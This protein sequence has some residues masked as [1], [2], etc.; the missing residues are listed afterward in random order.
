MI[1]YV[2]YQNINDPI[3]IG[4]LKKI[5]AQISAMKDLS[6][7]EIMLTYYSADFVYLCDYNGKVIKREFAFTRK[8]VGEIIERWILEYE[9][10][11]TYIR[12]NK[13]DKWLID[14]LKWHKKNGIRCMIEIPTY[15]YDDEMDKNKNMMKSMND[16]LFRKQLKENING[17][18]TYAVCEKVFDMDYISIS[19]GVDIND[20]KIRKKRKKDNKIV[21]VAVSGMFYWQGYERVIEGIANYYKNGGKKNVEFWLVGDGPQLEQYS[22][23]INELNLKDRIIIK[24]YKS[25]KALDDIYD[26]AD[27]AIG[28][29]GRYKVGT[30]IGATLKLREYCAKAIPFIYSCPDFSFKGDEPY[31][32]IVPDDASPLDINEIVDFYNRCENEDFYMEE[33]RKKAEMEFSWHHIMKPVVECLIDRKI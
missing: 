28:G 4:V 3:F 26:N 9:I 32:M 24:G 6:K 19:N 31:S 33:M 21:L 18:C 25:G 12:Y 17:L 22:N 29:L 2:T 16:Y 14:F 27:I 5:K 13:S 1:L 15:P 30:G 7:D 11:N 20:I 8:Q 10:K 23:M